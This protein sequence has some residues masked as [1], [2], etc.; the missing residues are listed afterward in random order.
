M[1]ALATG[2]A[3]LAAAVVCTWGFLAAAVRAEHRGFTGAPRAWAVAA[4]VLSV[5][6]LLWLGGVVFAG[7]GR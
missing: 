5:G 6:S 3:G 7:W 1:T 4:L 2:F